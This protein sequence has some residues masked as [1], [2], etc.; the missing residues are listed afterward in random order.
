MWWLVGVLLMAAVIVLAFFAGR[1][2]ELTSLDD[3][4]TEAAAA[5]VATVELLD[6]HEVTGFDWDRLGLFFAYTSPEYVKEE[7]GVRMPAAGDGQ[8][9]SDS[10]EFLAFVYEGDRVLKKACWAVGG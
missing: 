5:A 8:M 1:P 7:L 2:W 4:L 6:L 10:D 3:D 9:N